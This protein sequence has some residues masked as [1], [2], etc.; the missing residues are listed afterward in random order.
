[1]EFHL[2]FSF[3]EVIMSVDRFAPWNRDK[4]VCGEGWTTGE[5]VMNEEI[6]EMTER[7]MRV[8]CTASGK[9]AEWQFERK[10]PKF[11]TK[12]GGLSGVRKEEWL[13]R[14]ELRLAKIEIEGKLGLAEAMADT[15]LRRVE[16]KDLE[17]TLWWEENRR[18]WRQKEDYRIFGTV[19]WKKIVPHES[20]RDPRY[21]AAAEKMAEECGVSSAVFD[22]DWGL[23]SVEQKMGILKWKQLEGELKE[24]KM[25]ADLVLMRWQREQLKAEVGLAK[26]L[27]LKKR[28]VGEEIAKK[29]KEERVRKLGTADSLCPNE[30][31]RIERREDEP[32]G[33]WEEYGKEVEAAQGWNPMEE[34]REIGRRT[35]A[36]PKVM[37]SARAKN[38]DDS[39]K[40]DKV[41]ASSSSTHME[42]A[43]RF[44]E[45]NTD[46]CWGLR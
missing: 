13:K 34:A 7:M 23:V 32:S 16:E 36:R 45:K 11:V 46:D 19:G 43:E 37:A 35:G 29:K 17:D 6:V 18:V 33:W 12:M 31:W 1:M 39:K 26:R 2:V 25:E 44:I 38:T 4:Y 30:I 40:S 10:A 24:Q 28:I 22:K 9:F 5:G 42:A 27:E 8:V 41:T 20:E 3:A 21:V 14:E 15:G